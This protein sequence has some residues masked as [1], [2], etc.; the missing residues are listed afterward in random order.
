MGT[1]WSQHTCLTSATDWLLFGS[2]QPE[3]FAL[4]KLRP[5]KTLIVLNIKLIDETFLN[6]TTY[7]S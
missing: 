4:P 6:A 5:A 3:N 2:R 1:D 7:K